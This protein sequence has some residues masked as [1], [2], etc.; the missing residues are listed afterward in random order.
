M[1]INDE[2]F[3]GNDGRE[4]TEECLLVL[5]LRWRQAQSGK[6]QLSVKLSTSAMDFPGLG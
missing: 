2:G 4:D 6:S 1:L 5:V 3:C